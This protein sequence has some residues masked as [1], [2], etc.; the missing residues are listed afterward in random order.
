MDRDLA[1]I[2][3]SLPGLVLCADRNGHVEFVNQEWSD[4]SGLVQSVFTQFEWRESISGGELANWMARWDA[5]I[6]STE[7]G[8]ICTYLRR[9]DGLD[10]PFRVRLK[11]TFADRGAVARW[12]VIACPVDEVKSLHRTEREILDDI[13]AGIAVLSPSGDVDAVNL[14]MMN[15]FNKP[16][17]VIK[18]WVS[19]DIVHPDDLQR[20]IRTI[21][22]AMH[23]G[24]PYETEHRLRGSSGTYRWFQ[25]CGNP[26]LEVG[27]EVRR[28]YALHIDIDE[29][30]RAEEALRGR[31]GDLRAIINALPATAWSTRPDG[32]VDFLSEKWLDYAGMSHEQ[33]GGFGWADVIHPDDAKRLFSYWEGCLASGEPVDIEAR[34]RRYDGVYRWFLFRANPLCNDAGTIV[35][36]YGT[37]IDI[38]DRKR[39]EEE[40]LASE[41]N[42][43]QIINTIPIVAWAT[44]PDGSTDFLHSRWLEYAGMSHAEAEGWGWY[45]AI[46][47]N[48]QPGLL[49]NW[50]NC[51]ASGVPTDAEARIRRFD[52]EYR[53]FLFR[54]NPLR[55][56]HGS[57]IKWYGTNIDIEDRKRAEQALAESERQSRLIVDTIPG[58]VSIF[59]PNGGIDGI[60]EQF[61][62][63]LG[64]TSEDF[65]SWRD[66]GTV[67]PDDLER[68]LAGVSR[69][70]SSGEPMDFET[71]LKR[72][73]GTYRW[74]HLRGNPARDAGGEIM[75][76]YCLMTDIDDRRHAEESVRESEVTLRRIINTLPTTAWSTSPDGSV[77]FLSD[78]WLNYA[79]VT[80]EQASGFGWGQV[81]HPDDAERLFTYWEARLL[82][83]ESV[84]VEARM[85]RADGVYRWF[86]FRADPLRDESGSI[87]KWYGT[88]IDIEDRRRVDEALR[89]SERHARL[90][91]DTIPGMIALF[92]PKGDLIGA[93]HQLLEYFGKPIE[94]LKDWAA[95]SVVHP[96]DIPGCLEAFTK[97]IAKGEPCEVET[98]FVRYDGV[99]RWFQL[100][101]LPLTDTN[102]GIIRWYVLLTDIDDRKSAEQKLRRSEAFLA[103]A[104]RVS[105]TGSFAWEVGSEDV[106][107]SEETYRIYGFELDEPVTLKNIRNKLHPDNLVTFERVAEAAQ[108]EGSNF[109]HETR[110]V[111][112]DQS[113]KYVRVVAHNER[114][115]DGALELRG[116]VRDVTATRLAEEALSKARSDL[117]RVAR[118]TSLGILTASIAHEVNQPLAG[119][120]N[121]ANAC[122]RLLDSE[123]PNLV[124]A[125]ETAR[126]TIRDGNRAA[127]VIARLRALFSKNPFS[128]QE[129]DLNEAVHEVIALSRGDIQ[130]NR[131]VLQSELASGLPSVAGD[132]IQLQQVML[133]LLRNATEAMSGVSDRERRVLIK[134]Q[135][136]G[137]DQVC[138]SVSDAGIGFE[139]ATA[140]RLFEAFYSTKN[141]GMG[142]GLS[143][144][145]SIVD[146]H[147]GS[148][149]AASNE[150]PGVT[151][152]FAVPV[153]DERKLVV[154]N[155]AHAHVFNADGQGRGK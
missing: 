23:A 51:L 74:F 4:F 96:D 72:F 105:K 128:I 100:R 58:L 109:D 53:W 13:P 104:Q 35:K 88:N 55:D 62:E 78:R 145:Q 68:H 82:S 12:F 29:R 83:G 2:L 1:G 124:V 75:R 113:I 120:V 28:W 89:E 33:A 80:Y 18:D 102:R 6:A 41:Q 114:N 67:H 8:E 125:K 52:G 42:L 70:L 15:Y 93:N 45:N 107:W 56:E 22:D 130:R 61:L 21:G 19:S 5:V 136:H 147:Q 116:A 138:F 16:E 127:D 115:K 43:T 142:I 149:W 131:V 139:N 99:Y 103:D 81:I 3:N 9:H 106:T 40:L 39:A 150:G 94:E 140:E 141:E 123:P 86:L 117:A 91:V 48:D 32:Y 76:W 37:N 90:I 54:G 155:I 7:P 151:V 73:D 30:K 26:L 34:M 66:N 137:A 25:I 95:D 84:D 24:E 47:P 44:L 64:Q 46:H 152:S 98:R 65:Q 97:S 126:R 77:D 153:Y 108:H 10:Q 121:N 111:M 143:V 148:L 154:G 110:M 63:Y 122:L 135:P 71:R 146:A 50:R 60:N 17:V 79:G 144:S 132:R 92:S 38:E 11:P 118:V 133:N 27:G 57:I 69:S 36:W 112:A 85:R 31:E 119:I 14:H 20:V 49:A 101:G 87:I 134:T 129:V 59:G